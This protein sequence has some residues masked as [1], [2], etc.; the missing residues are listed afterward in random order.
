[1][2]EAY[3]VVVIGVC[4]FLFLLILVGIGDFYG[5]NWEL[6]A[7]GITQFILIVV[8]FAFGSY[9]LVKIMERK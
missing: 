4:V 7:Q 2:D 3:A 9:V 8:G 5:G 6:V 1:M